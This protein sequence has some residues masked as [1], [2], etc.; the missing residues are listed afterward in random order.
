MGIVLGVSAALLCTALAIVSG[1]TR[2]VEASFQRLRGSELLMDFDT[3]AHDPV[4]VER[5]WRGR[6]G[7]TDTVTYPVYR[8]KGK[9]LFRGAEVSSL[10]A[11]T[12]R[13]S[14]PT[15]NLL[16]VVEGAA[17][18]RPGPGEVWIPTS[19][20]YG[21]EPPIRIGESFRFPAGDRSVDLTVSAIVVDPLSS[22]GFIEPIRFWV[23]PGELASVF[24]L[25][26]LTEVWIGVRFT[27]PGLLEPAW[28]A[29]QASLPAGFNGLRID[30]AG[31][32]GAYVLLQR[33]IG[34]ILLVF[35]AVSAAILL[36]ILSFTVSA[37]ILSE[38]RTIGVLKAQG[39]TSG[40]L[41]AAYIVQHL[42]VAA[43][44]LPAGAALSI[45]LVKVLAGSLV[46]ALGLLSASVPLALPAALTCGL[47]AGLVAL[48]AG[49][50]ARR[51]GS[52]RPAE[53]MRFGAPRAPGAG[54]RTGAG[55][56]L[57]RLPVPLGLG[58]RQLVT[59]RR[60]SILLVAA[61][62][63]TLFV[64][65]F[66]VNMN[67]TFADMGTFAA[68][69]GLDAS[70]VT[71]TRS[72]GRFATDHAVL[73]AE[74]S[75]DARVAAVAEHSPGGVR[76]VIPAE[77]GRPAQNV[78]GSAWG[79][80][81]E[82]VGLQNLRGRSPRA[83][84]E[85][86]LAATTAREYGKDVGDTFDL[87]LEGSRF[88]L[89]VTGIYQST[90][91][92]GRGF[93]IPL[94]VLEQASPGFQPTFYAV[95]LKPG[96]DASAWVAEWGKRYGAALVVKRTADIVR[97]SA[98]TIVMS[99]NAMELLLA[100]V[101]AAVAAIIVFNST[102]IRVAQLRGELG[103]FKS[104]GMTQWQL[105]GSQL[106]TLACLTVVAAAAALPLAMVFSPRLL[107]TLGSSLGLVRFPTRIT[108]VGTAGA[109]IACLLIALASCLGAARRILRIS[110]RVLIQE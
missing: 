49:L 33:L 101:F 51:V 20:A 86:S 62:G 48:S 22:A 3:L 46:R 94:G 39:F 88:T 100:I 60:R 18:S 55:Q 34:L 16:Q 106:F 71:I 81:V 36:L 91:N 97:E 10:L 70:D 42:T 82:A 105:A 28:D 104:L 99:M 30:Y 24:P 90:S 52:I 74:L 95:V 56:G 63:L 37:A 103:V 41:V 40:N 65:T 2:P 14:A 64:F 32:I 27:S 109:V 11:L 107:S 26:E 83:D 61:L 50:A 108:P 6:E 4:S 21:R 87:L 45:L 73:M 13:P 53:A 69:L 89:L 31:V 84:N 15:Q 5:W 9:V 110:P 102:V 12:E 96:I 68:A 57:A 93:R 54:R 7:V 78:I 92:F 44:S 17:S 19:F 72:T 79:G 58:L 66:S 8:P 43:L 85:V 1:I 23:A 47:L 76:A 25:S 77:A 29:F 80:D 67:S 98:T 38:Y 59:D 35:S 75:A